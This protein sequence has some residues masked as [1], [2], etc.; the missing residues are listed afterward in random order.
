[1]TKKD[2]KSLKILISILLNLFIISGYSAVQIPVNDVYNGRRGIDFNNNWKFQIGDISGANAT[3]FDDSAWRKLSLPHDWSIE[4]AFNQNSPAGGGGGY[5][6]GGIGWYRKT[7]NLPDSVSGKRITIQFEGIYMNSTV[8]ING[9][10]LGTRP[11]GYSSFEYDLTAYIKTGPTPNVI[12]VKV[13]NN[14]PNSRWYSGSGIYRNVW[15]T[16]TDPVHIAYCGSFVTTTLSGVSTADVSAITRVQNHSNS[17]QNITVVTTIY[18]RLGN[19]VATSTCA[20]VSVENDGERTFGLKLRISNPVLWSISNPYLYSVKTQIFVDKKVKDTFT[21]TLGVRSISVNPATG[22]WLNDQ[23][24]KLHGVCMHHD[25]GSLGAAQNYRA[26]ERQVE[27]LK[28]FGCN[29]IRTSHN[30]PAPELLDICDRLGLV[31][32]DEVFD[33]W[34]TGKNVNDYGIFFDTWAQQDVQDWVRRDRNH[35][36]VVMWSIGNEIPQQGDASGYSIAQKLI[37]W[38]HTDDATRPITQALNYQA[39]LA[40]LLGIVGYNY[41]SGG[42]YDYDHNNNP[43]WVIMGSETSSAVRTRGVYHIP[44]NQNILTALDMQCSSYDNS[45]V[46]WGHS[47]EDSWEFDKTRP[48]VVG[49]F[50]WTGFDYIGEPTPYGWPAKSSYFGIVDMCGFPK[51]IYYFYQSQ[52][53]SKP[54]VHLLPHWNWAEGDSIPVWAYSNCDSVS[55]FRNGMY[56]S[57]KKIQTLKPYHSEWRMPFTEG[58]I[59]AFAYKNGVAVAKDSITTAATASKIVLKSDRDTIHADGYDQAYIETDMVD[60]G[61]TLDPD[62]GNQVTY[63]ISGPGKIVGVDNGNPISLESFKAS[64]R[65][66][67]NGKCLAIVQSTGAEGQ[68]VLTAS[69][70]PVLNNI[71]LRKHSHADSE[72]IYT[73]T[74][75]AIGKSSASDSQQENNPTTA[76]NDGNS[77]TRWCA[78]DANTG[79]WWK[80]DLGA[81]HNITGT[82][83]Y[84]EHENTYQYKIE[85]STDNSVWKLSVNKTSNSISAQTMDDNFTETARYIRITVTGGLNSGNWASFFEFRVFDGTYSISKGKNLASAGNDGNLS[86]YWSAA[87]GNSG[88]SWSVDLGVI[89]N[90]TGSQVVWLSS[91]IAYKYKIEASSDS[92]NW[93]LA[94]DKTGN[95]STL[96]IMTDNFSIIARYIRITITGG[97]SNTNKAGFSEFRIF[98]GSYT[99]FSPSSVTINCVKPACISCLVDSTQI[100]PLV[101]IN[102]SVWQQSASALLCKGGDVSFS[103]LSSDTTGWLWNGPNGYIAGTKQINLSNIQPRDTGIYKVTHKNTF[104]NFNLNLVKDSISLFFK[105]NDNPFIHGSI[106]TVMTGDSIILS[107]VPPDSIGWRWSWTG[108][109]GFSAVS[110]A[111]KITVTDTIQSGVY[112]SNGS[113]GFSCGTVSQIFNLTVEK[114]TGIPVVESGS[115]IEIY[116]NPSNNGI[117]NIKNCENCK[118]SVFTLMG[119]LISENI[120]NSIVNVID[121]SGQPSGVYIIRF[122]SAKINIFRKVIIQ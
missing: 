7:F 73:L 33:C 50:I 17:S 71:A 42:T 25:L 58:K 111:I 40:P 72:D 48:Y 24:I 45:V 32:M 104:F 65:Q 106:A 94:A 41:A 38:V 70:T 1:M 88:H 31:V 96:Q 108:P 114:S 74:D 2:F 6:D 43:L 59:N 118:I 78:N 102:N 15:L 100:K 89:K 57:T 51:D 30:P 87:D 98:D 121:L 49:Q 34:E 83:I 63:S 115:N 54:M 47:A 68:I 19:G 56:L 37:K 35:P 86:S 12:A 28:S 13:N 10:Q 64:T 101:N 20:P 122:F 14:Q 109:N 27:I 110:R 44:T 80:V 18:D 105:I 36:S 99:S 62:A 61:N 82:E 112:T 55:L 39:L 93:L 81:N 60:S 11:Y 92:T 3:G 8:W 97:T 103:T 85:T 21:S 84:W 117:F 107:P 22:F 29:A 53:T 116:P 4:Q 66:T 26:L 23:N 91:G 79:H 119:K 46:P 113:D 90:I 77:S 69:T 75:I 16:V 9:Q 67:F 120:G 5:L 95:T 76:G 52:W